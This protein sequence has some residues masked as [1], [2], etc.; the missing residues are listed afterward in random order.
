MVA[1]ESVKI[2]DAVV[3]GA[4]ITSQNFLTASFVG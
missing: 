3:V 1:K 2:K 4:T